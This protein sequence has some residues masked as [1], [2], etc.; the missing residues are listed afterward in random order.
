[1]ADREPVAISIDLLGR[2]VRV[3][4]GWAGRRSGIGRRWVR[5]KL[6]SGVI[7]FTRS[8]VACVRSPGGKVEVL[9]V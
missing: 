4:S 9:H 2:Q 6:F 3:V 7:R 5:W 1:M 8:A